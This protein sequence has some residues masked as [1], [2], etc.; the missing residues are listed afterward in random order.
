[1]WGDEITERFT[2]NQ[3]ELISNRIRKNQ[4]LGS[5]LLAIFYLGYYS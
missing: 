4:G 5:P 1:M 2:L 3:M